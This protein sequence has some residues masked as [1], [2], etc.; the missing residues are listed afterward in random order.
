MAQE[1][2]VLVMGEAEGAALGK[3][4]AAGGW[5]PR[6][7]EHARFS[8]AGGGVTATLY[9]SGKLVV[10]GPDLDAFAERFLGS[11]D[12]L[13]GPPAAD[14][15][16]IGTDE[17]GKGD[18]FGPLVVAAV[19]VSRDDVA[20]LRRI[21][22]RDSK[23]LSDATVERVAAAVETSTP[24]E[25]VALDPPEYNRRQAETGNVNRLLGELHAQ[26]ILALAARVPGRRV[27]TDEFGDPTHVSR[28][29]S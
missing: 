11:R 28:H 27:L 2:R 5:T 18:Y 9:R 26:V 25:V 13:A 21:G 1:T 22:V 20:R 15:E 3:R 8:Y 4:L 17:A 29:V 10:Q 7:V 6:S 23:M 19:Y 24:H 12:A 16:R 14:D